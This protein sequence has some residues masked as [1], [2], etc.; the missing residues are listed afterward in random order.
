MAN[1]TRTNPS[2]KRYA[3]MKQRIARA[4]GKAKAIGLWY[5]LANVTLAVLAC[6]P[7]LVLTDE[8]L[9]VG[10]GVMN[11]WT[12]FT[13]LAEG[14]E[15]K[16]I[17][18]TIA[19][20]YGVM[21]LIILLNVLRSIFKL[22]WLFKRKASRLYGFNR[23]MYAMDDMGN[24][25]ASTFASIVICHL[26]I[27]LVAVDVTVNPI[28]YAVLGVGVFFHFACGIPSGKV[29]LFDLDN[30]VLE[31]KRE[32]GSFASFVRNLLQ[33]AVVAAITYFFIACSPVRGLLDTLL[34]E[35]GVATLTEDMNALIIALLQ[36]LTL[37]WLIAMIAYATGTTEFDMDGADAS[38]R[39]SFLVFSILALLCAGGTYV[40]GQFV[41]QMELHQNVLI[42][43]IVALVA[44]ILELILINRP[45]EKTENLDE[46]DVGKYLTENYEKSGVYM[47]T[48]ATS[49]QEFGDLDVYSRK[50]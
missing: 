48:G 19:L 42:I 43:A 1:N 15:G 33:L 10:L 5:L 36:V 13:G 37:V 22:G 20:I 35:D 24:R 2:S 12:V 47:N 31:Q 21:L 14:V 41:A 44:V 32:V 9:G 25:F 17:A 28:A 11:F 8:T 40:Y 46:V 34:A 49:A 27:A 18:L 7:L 23:N 30:G 26:L 16:E 39:K 45:K 29:S 4:Q 6:L 38:G 50:R 3:Y